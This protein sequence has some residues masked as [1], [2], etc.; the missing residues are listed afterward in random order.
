VLIVKTRQ[1]L[2]VPRFDK[3]NWT[4]TENCWDVLIQFG[5]S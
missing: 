2:W 4:L 3:R 1:E 5:R